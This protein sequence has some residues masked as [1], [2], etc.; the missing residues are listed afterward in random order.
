MEKNEELNQ[1]IGNRLRDLRKAQGWNRAAIAGLLYKKDGSKGMTEQAYRKIELGDSVLSYK[2]AVILAKEYHVSERF[3]LCM[4]DVETEEKELKDEFLSNFDTSASSKEFCSC[5]GV[6][7][8]PCI[9]EKFYSRKTG[10]EIPVNEWPE[11]EHEADPEG[12]G[13]IVT[14]S[15]PSGL[16]V[17]KKSEYLVRVRIAGVEYVMESE[18]WSSVLEIA[19]SAALGALKAACSEFDRTPKATP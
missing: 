11:G 7:Y 16:D 14:L 8:Y 1:K 5:L 4:T 13:E 6:K 3:I 9:T 18:K 17:E 19:K 15:T 2:N 10:K 12:D